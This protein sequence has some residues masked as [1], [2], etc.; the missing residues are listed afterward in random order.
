MIFRVD[1]KTKIYITLLALNAFA[2][3]FMYCNKKLCCQFSGRF[4]VLSLEDYHTNL[5]QKLETVSNRR[6]FDLN[7]SIKSIGAYLHLY[8]HIND[9]F[10]LCFFLNS[11][12]FF[13]YLQSSV[14]N[15]LCNMVCLFSGLD[16]A[17]NVY[18]NVYKKTLLYTNKFFNFSV[19]SNTCLRSRA[20]RVIGK[21]KTLNHH[22]TLSNKT[23]TH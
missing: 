20:T 18:L 15:F 2:T 14:G 5:L 3:L 8:Y 23:Q 19:N 1:N 13:I 11:R 22:I 17:Y 10:G 16:T 7:F 4:V 9:V 21:I 6:R 12:F